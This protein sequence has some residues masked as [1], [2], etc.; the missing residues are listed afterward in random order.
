MEQTELRQQRVEVNAAMRRCERLE[1]TESFRELPL[2]AHLAPAA[3]LVPRDC[4]VYQPLEE[5]ALAWRRGAPGLFELL[6]RG[7]VLAG[8][9][10]RDAGLKGGLELLRLPPGRRTSATG[11]RGR[12]R[13]GP[14][15]RRTASRARGR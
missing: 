7:E 8:A 12:T 4:Y 6:V 15:S 2:C 9:N 10:Q 1:P 5:V 14:S 13:S 11:S 3:C